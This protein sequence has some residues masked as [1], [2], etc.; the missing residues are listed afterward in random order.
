MDAN[1][2]NSENIYNQKLD[3]KLQ[4]TSQNSKNETLQ[5]LANNE[6]ETPENNNNHKNN[7]L[8]YKTFNPPTSP[9]NSSITLYPSP[10]IPLHTHNHPTFLS[11]IY[12]FTPLLI[13][14]MLFFIFNSS[15]LPLVLSFSNSKYNNDEHLVT[16]IGTCETIMNISVYPLLTGLAAVIE[17]LGSQLYSGKNYYMLGCVLNKVRVSSY[18]LLL[19]LT[20]ICY[21]FHHKYIF[22][23]V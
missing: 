11:T 14:N 10:S 1:N 4:N 18:V 2:K 8:N 13:I 3:N 12:I 9:L 19:F 6:N 20:A 17:I 21:T 23:S 22:Y 15:Q 16:A 5:N 7:N